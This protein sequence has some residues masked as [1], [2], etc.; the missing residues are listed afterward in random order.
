MLK[1]YLV[2]TSLFKEEMFSSLTIDE[3]T[4]ANRFKIEEDKIRFI[5]GRKLLAYALNDNNV[6]NKEIVIGEFGKPSLKSN[7]LY[8][9]LSHSGE[10]VVC[11]VSSSSLGVDI[12]Q[13]RESNELVVRKC[14]S[15]SEQEYVKDNDTFT[16]VWTLK[17]SYIKYLGTGLKT[18]LD[19]FETISNGHVSFIDNLVFTTVLFDNYY[20]SICHVSSKHTEFKYLTVL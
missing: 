3:Q 6:L 19:S 4:R 5:V 1:V 18:K 17:E 16:K 2:K 20:L 9:N 15:P 11:G 13:V 7:E 14:F 10:Y 8:F 12:E